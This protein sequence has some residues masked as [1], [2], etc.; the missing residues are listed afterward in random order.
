MLAIRDP[1]PGPLRGPPLP[2][3]AVSKLGVARCSAGVPTGDRR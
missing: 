2:I 1:S 3:E